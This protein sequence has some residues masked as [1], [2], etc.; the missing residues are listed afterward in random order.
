[1]ILAMMAS[2]IIATMITVIIGEFA[3]GIPNSVSCF[4]DRSIRT[5]Y[6]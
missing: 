1:M 2:M 4:H 5:G 6:R 3:S